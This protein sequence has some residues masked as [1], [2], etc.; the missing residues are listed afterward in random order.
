MTQISRKH[1][2]KPNV[3]W[4]GVEL[5]TDLIA[6]PKPIFAVFPKGK[7]KACIHIKGSAED[8]KKNIL[9]ILERKPDNSL[10]VI[11]GVAKPQPDD[12]GT[13]KEHLNSAGYPKAWGASDSHIDYLNVFVVE[14]DPKNM[15]L[16]TQKLLIE[17]VLPQCSFSVSSGNRSLHTY[18]IAD[19]T[20][21]DKWRN[22]QERLI[23]L[24]QDKVPEL[25]V[26]SS[27]KNPARVMR[28]VGGR[29]SKTNKFCEFFEFNDV[30]YS[31]EEFDKLLPQLPER[32]TTP[33][34]KEKKSFI[35]DT[36]RDD[37]KCLNNKTPEEKRSYIV[38][39][40]RYIPVHEGAGKGR[41]L[42]IC[43]PVLAAL[44]NEFGDAAISVCDEAGWNN[45]DLW[46]PAFEIEYLNEPECHLGTVVHWARECGWVHPYDKAKPEPE[47]HKDFKLADVFPKEV[48]NSIETVT[49]YLPHKDTL[50][51]LTFMSAVAPLI[52]LGTKI[53][54]ISTTNFI[55]PLNLF[56]CVIGASGSKK[57][58]LMNLLLQDPLKEVKKNLARANFKAGQ[59]YDR[60]LAAY[61]KDKE[62]DK[63]EKP[64]YPI[65]T[66]RDSTTEALERQLMDQEKAKMG[67]LRFNDEL[68][69]LIKSFN[70]Y[71]QGRGSDEEFLLELYDG[72]GFNT[73]RMDERRY[74]EETA[75]T[76]FGGGQPEVLAKLHR[77]QDAN[78]LWARFV[79]DFSAAIPKRL[80]TV[81]TPEERSK[82][83]K[84]ANYLGYFISEV[85]D[86]RTDTLEL[87]DE[88]LKRFSDYELE[89]Q[90]LAANKK[91]KS[92]H[93]ATCNKSAGKV[94][95]V[96]GILW[97]MNQVQEKIKNKISQGDAY[98]DLPPD[99]QVDITTINNAIELI[100]YWDSVSINVD[101]KASENSRDIILRRLLNIAA[102]SK[103]PVPYHEIYK[104]LSFDHR[105]IYKYD[106][107]SELIEKLQELGLG[108]VSNGPREGK[109]F[110]A[111][112]PWPTG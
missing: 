70:K 98:C 102:K 43:I 5:F 27:I 36:A 84:A 21:P 47:V 9:R 62:G 66:T 80:P 96:A 37:A 72:Q 91:L 52:R 45:G 17:K 3:V 104:Q 35:S 7:N 49:A 12:W 109:M 92:S 73:I 13:K 93:A 50:K 20:P 63:P 55:V 88:A 85:K 44:V 4:D 103:A 8:F 19:R 48:S 108:L 39:M 87:T 51:M 90:E 53:N 54:C 76:V 112:K 25:N 97:I 24:L 67:L 68:A 10:G 89:R 59:E 57:T 75:V 46:N 40:L 60:N 107:I 34:Y 32:K 30:G 31:W 74:C 77:G 56:A 11:L 26:D 71:S 6:N 23:Q 83:K 42:K 110:K 38:D 111:E 65:I 2:L 82:F 105:K 33:K 86:F 29:H 95:R 18:W 58:P 99:N 16:T 79:F 81:V 28:C 15:D 64:P 78:G 106:E 101:N 69:G 1:N 41:R 61:A 100:N 94:A 22:I 14:G